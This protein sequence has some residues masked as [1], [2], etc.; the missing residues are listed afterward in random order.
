MAAELK[1]S[2]EEVKS[3]FKKFADTD[4]EV[5]YAFGLGKTPDDSKL[6]V[7]KSRKGKALANT[8]GSDAKF[9]KIGFGTISVENGKAIFKPI[10]QVGHLVKILRPDLRKVGYAIEILEPAEGGGGDGEPLSP[11][12]R[13]EWIARMAGLEKEIDALLETLAA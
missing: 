4:H 2:K 3:L 11:E 12:A 8:M 5:N 10:K 1:F 9:K 13:K 7:H 6:L